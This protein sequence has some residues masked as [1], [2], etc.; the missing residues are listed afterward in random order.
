[1]GGN[2]INIMKEKHFAYKISRDSAGLVCNQSEFEEDKMLDVLK[3][4]QHTTTKGI[5]WIFK[6]WNGKPQEALCIIDCEHGR[7]YYHHSGEVEDLEGTIKKL[8]HGRE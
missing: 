6:Q 7:I 3:D 5:Y 4:I 2:W 1:M 8:H